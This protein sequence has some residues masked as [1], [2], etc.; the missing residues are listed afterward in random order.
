MGRASSPEDEREADTTLR[1]PTPAPEEERAVVLLQLATISSAFPFLPPSRP[2]VFILSSSSV[3]SR[4]DV[5][6]NV[7]RKCFDPLKQAWKHIVVANAE[8]AK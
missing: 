1:S 7:V 3:A 8:G 2:A 4:R 5:F 6:L